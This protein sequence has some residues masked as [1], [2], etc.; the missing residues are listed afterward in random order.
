MWVEYAEK[1]RYNASQVPAEWH[2]WLHFIIDLTGGEL[3]LLKPK[4][5]GAEHKE[6]WSGEGKQD[7][8]VE[9]E[10]GLIFTKTMIFCSNGYIILLDNDKNCCKMEIELK[11]QMIVRTEIMEMRSTSDAQ[12]KDH[13]NNA[14]KLQVYIQ[15]FKYALGLQSLS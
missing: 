11:A 12:L 6:N 2:G 4:R 14:N 8:Q 10:I 9:G 1:T 3:L 13:V 7:P 5:Y 15:T